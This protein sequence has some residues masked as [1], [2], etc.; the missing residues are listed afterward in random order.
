MA[1]KLFVK[2]QS[3]NPSGRPKGNAEARKLLSDMLIDRSGQLIMTALSLAEAGN[4]KILQFLLERLVPKQIEGFKGFDAKADAKTII[5]GCLQQYVD[6]EISSDALNDTTKAVQARAAM[7][8][9]LEM[10]TKID[11]LWDAKTNRE[12]VPNVQQQI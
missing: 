8:E 3:G 7:V 11:A 12:G 4:E 5:T 2:G 6:G 9:L 10:K 1:K